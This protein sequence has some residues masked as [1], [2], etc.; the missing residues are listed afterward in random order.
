MSFP[1]RQ[2]TSCTRCQLKFK[3]LFSDD[4]TNKIKAVINQRLSGGL[5]DST[6]DDVAFNGIQL[7]DLPP[8]SVEEVAKLIATIPDRSPPIDVIPTSIIKSCSDVFAPLIARLAALSF[9]ERNFQSHYKTAAVTPLIKKKGFDRDN[10]A[11]L[12]TDL[13]IQCQTLS[14]DCFC[15]Q[16]RSL[17]GKVAVHTST[18]CSL[19]TEVDIR[20]RMRCSS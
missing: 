10:T 15:L 18:N 7:A 13:C 17:C 5:S 6:A 8:P 2:T 19:P 9:S 4:K 3:R 11:N 14:R 12:Q 1:M 20:P 16:S